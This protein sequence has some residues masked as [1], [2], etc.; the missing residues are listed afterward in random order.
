MLAAGFT[1]LSDTIRQFWTQEFLRTQTL[2]YQWLNLWREPAAGLALQPASLFPR[3]PSF[4]QFHRVEGD[5]FRWFDELLVLIFVS[6]LPAPSTHFFTDLWRQYSVGF[7]SSLSVL[8]SA[9]SVDV[10]G[11]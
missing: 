5:Y 4:Q 6:V 7:A 1:S 10:A 2:Y 9:P 11:S 3:F 8:I